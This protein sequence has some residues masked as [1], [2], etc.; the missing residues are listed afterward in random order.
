[1]KGVSKLGDGENNWTEQGGYVR[2]MS[3]RIRI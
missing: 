1:M 3:R 2:R